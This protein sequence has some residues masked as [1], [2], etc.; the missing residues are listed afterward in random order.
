MKFTIHYKESKSFT[1]IW[2][3]IERKSW[4]KLR[5]SFKF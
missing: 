3:Q 5:S 4:L 1:I 2:A